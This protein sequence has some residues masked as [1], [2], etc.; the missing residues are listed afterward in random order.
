MD[1]K[2][3]LSSYLR[4]LEVGC[5]LGGTLQFFVADPDCESITAIAKL[6]AAVPSFITGLA[7]TLSGRNGSAV[8]VNHQPTT[9]PATCGRR[10]SDHLRCR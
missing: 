8:R 2:F 9:N 1:V 3:P 5:Y 10:L 4:Y 6:V 7:S